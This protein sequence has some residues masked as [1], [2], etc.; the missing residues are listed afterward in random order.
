MNSTDTLFELK[1]ELGGRLK[2]PAAQIALFKDAGLRQQVT[3]RDSSTLARCGFKNGDML[4]VGNQQVS[5][6]SVDQKK[7]EIAKKEEEAKKEEQAKKE[8][9]AKREEEQKKEKAA[10]KEKED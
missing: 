5:L 10:E 1:S 9:D 2:L 6:A 3:D 7:A 4:H 8:A